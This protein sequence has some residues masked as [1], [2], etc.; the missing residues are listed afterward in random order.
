MI[1]KS[2]YILITLSTVLALGIA[3]HSI[4]WIYIIKLIIGI[5]TFVVFLYWKLL[6]YKNQM[7]PNY[8]KILSSIERFLGP[9]MRQMNYIQSLKLGNHLSMDMRPY[10][11]CSLCIILLIVL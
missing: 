11:L 9:I 3:I 2:D 6:P 5:V 4:G 8:E 10:Y 1:K 7:Y